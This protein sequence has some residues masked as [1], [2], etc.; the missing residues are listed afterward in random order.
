MYIQVRERYPTMRPKPSGWEMCVRMPSLKLYL[1][2]FF[3]MRV[4]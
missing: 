4:A 2:G 1:R 3:W